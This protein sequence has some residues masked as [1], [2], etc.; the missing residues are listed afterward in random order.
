MDAS[1]YGGMIATPTRHF[2][3]LLPVADRLRY[4]IWRALGRR[5]EITLRMAAGPRFRLPPPDGRNNDYGA[6]HE[7]F[8]S[9]CY[10]MPAAV[11]AN[12]PPVRRILDL[13]SNCGASLLWW[14]LHF[15]E[16]EI[17]GF[18]PHPA[19]YEAARCNLALNCLRS[20]V[21]LRPQAVGP[22]NDVA[23]LT[24][25]GTGASLH[26]DNAETSIEV[27]VVDLFAAVGDQRFDLVKIDIEG[28]EFPIL[29]DS[30]FDR[31]AP[32]LLVMEW[33][34]VGLVPDAH[35]YVH[36]RLSELGYK[37][38]DTLVV[39]KD[40]GVLWALRDQASS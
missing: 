11:Q 16:A 8:Q 9:R 39:Q 7:I 3:D 5:S 15:P 29:Q 19:N 24:N 2:R 14:K 40:H 32:P 17:L 23:R 35:A 25:R 22:H 30:R 27:P 6:F 28:A 26:Y 13:G 4:L 38:H 34:E 31:L 21:E 18:E 1:T 37:V 33:H 10:A 36:Q 12:L 20:E